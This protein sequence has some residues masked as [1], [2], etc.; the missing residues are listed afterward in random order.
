MIYA[1]V[2]NDHH[3]RLLLDLLGKN[4]VTSDEI[5]FISHIS[6]RNRILISENLP[7]IKVMGHPLSS[8][9]GYRNLKT[10]VLSYLHYIKLRSKFV[11][12][13]DDVLIIATEY[14]LNNAFLAKWMSK[15]RG[16]VYLFDEGIGFYFNNSSFH[17]SRTSLKDRWYL[18]L[19]KLAFYV[20]LIPAYP[21]KGFEGRMFA[22]I[23][24]RFI[25]GVY[26]R[27]RLPIDRPLKILGYRN[28]LNSVQAKQKKED[29]CVIVFGGN[30]SAFGVGEEERVLMRRVIR[31]LSKKFQKVLIKIHPGD[32]VSR[33]GNYDFFRQL[34]QEY[35]N[36]S[37]V[38]DVITGNEAIKLFRPK[39]VVGVLGATLFDSFF[40]GCQPIFLFNLLPAV[41]EFNV[42]EFVLT[43][44]GYQFIKNLDDIG[45]DYLSG[46][47]PEKILYDKSA[48]MPWESAENSPFKYIEGGADC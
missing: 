17:R 19:Y 6:P 38:D 44:L 9:M 39:V 11:F 42:C 20:A 28:L 3:S 21:R 16:S 26:S 37:E 30:L 1:S 31:D 48:K 5:I 40:F 43:D 24:D 47:A 4:Q 27:M 10:Y 14:Q 8:G 2:D 46:I 32:A 23:D 34:I 41:P 35:E 18:F 12:K 13:K 15:A 25:D 33:S 22:C 45:P 7:Q 29:G 36:V